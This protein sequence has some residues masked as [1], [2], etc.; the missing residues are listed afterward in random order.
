VP[1]VRSRLTEF[2]AGITAIDADYVRPRLAASHL[3]VD[4]GR[5]AFV[6]TGTSLSVP[7]L[8]AAL[9]AKDID[10]A[11]VDW[12]LATHVHL[13]HAGGAG[14]TIDCSAGSRPSSQRG[15]TM[16]GRQT[17]TT[18]GPSDSVMRTAVPSSVPGWA[19]AMRRRWRR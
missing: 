18:A 19:C 10:P 9:A 14:T 8:L 3:V 16:S 17:P 2:G 1:E 4:G 5:A 15:T 12:V 7:N 11:D 13:D 6:D